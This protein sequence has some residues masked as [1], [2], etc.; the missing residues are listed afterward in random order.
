[1]VVVKR[2]MFLISLRSIVAHIPKPNAKAMYKGRC[3]VNLMNGRFTSQ[4]GDYHLCK[5]CKRN[6][7]K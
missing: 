4:L 5:K 1:M 7:E 3:G 2:M 6:K